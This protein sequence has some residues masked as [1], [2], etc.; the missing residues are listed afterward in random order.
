[1]N[2]LAKSE[3][4]NN[5]EVYKITQ[6]GDALKIKDNVGR[7]FT[8]TD[9]IHYEDA[10][11]SSGELRELA[12]FKTEEGEY[13]ATNSATCIRSLMKMVETFGLPVTDVEIVQGT[14][15]SGRTY[16]DLKLL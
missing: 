13:F 12:A 4:L 8:I 2:I 7:V 15:R 10:D 14:S 5:R 11:T 9:Y 1:M 16:Y 3:G 6:S